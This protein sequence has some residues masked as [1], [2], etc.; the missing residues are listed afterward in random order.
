MGHLLPL[1]WVLRRFLF[2]FRSSET[3][4]NS[5]SV[6]DDPPLDRELVSEP[7]MVRAFRPAAAAQPILNLFVGD[8]GRFVN[9]GWVTAARFGR[10]PVIV[11]RSGRGATYW[12]ESVEETDIYERTGNPK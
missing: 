5:S 10:V 4:A 1:V 2:V 7:P 11:G 3:L 12:K 6:A 9:V 8:H